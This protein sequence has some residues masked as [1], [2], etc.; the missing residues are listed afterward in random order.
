LG[1]V[2]TFGNGYRGQLGL[3]DSNTCSIPTIV[4]G[5]KCTTVEAMS[6][7]NGHSLVSCVTPIPKVEEAG[8]FP[9]MTAGGP[10]DIGHNL[11]SLRENLHK[12]WQVSASQRKS[13]MDKVTSGHAKHEAVQSKMVNMGKDLGDRMQ[14]MQDEFFARIDSMH[15]GFDSSLSFIQSELD[16]QLTENGELMSALQRE[17]AAEERFR[18]DF[19]AKWQE[20]QGQLEEQL[21]KLTELDSLRETL[22]LR[23][24]EAGALKEEVD[25]TQMSLAQARG[26]KLDSLTVKEL[27]ELHKRNEEAQKLIHDAKAAKKKKSKK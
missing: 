11:R 14:G 17:S 10:T 8:E 9:D 13:L 15:Q 27:D 6:C 23:A 22:M 24:E 12:A 2:Y 3:G 26:E 21:P 4:P 1:H 20:I 19:V 16:T 7:G 25:R 5:V 18:V